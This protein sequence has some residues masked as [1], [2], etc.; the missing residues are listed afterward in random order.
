MPVI[1][2]VNTKGGSGKST[3]AN[4]LATTLARMGATVRLIDCD[5][6]GT[7]ARWGREGQSKY[8]DI[9][10]PL[11]VG[12]DLDRRGPAGRADDAETAVSVASYARPAG[13][14]AKARLGLRFV[15]YSV[16]GRDHER[17]QFA[18]VVHADG[19]S[20]MAGC[21]PSHA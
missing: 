5:P 6:Q 12:E 7:N 1:P 19:E 9:V 16:V 18:V 13:P 2:T 11:V 20:V 8:R 3:T 17:D 10:V 15:P 14:R 4:I 21:A